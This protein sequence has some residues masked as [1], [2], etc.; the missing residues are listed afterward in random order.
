MEL[1]GSS[2]RLLGD[3]GD[4]VE[5]V[6][7]PAL[8]VAVR[9]DRAEAAIVLLAFDRRDQIGRLARTII[10]PSRGRST[11]VGAI[12][13]NVSTL[14]SGMRRNSSMLLVTKPWPEARAV[15]A[16]HMSLAPINAPFAARW[17]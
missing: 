5:E 14:R 2:D 12:R 16:I 17:R 6:R 7:Q 1:A 15:A 11:V 9:S 4:T 3:L 10:Y 8:P 13:Q